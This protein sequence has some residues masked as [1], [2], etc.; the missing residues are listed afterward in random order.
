MAILL[1]AVVSGAAG[2]AEVQADFLVAGGGE[3]AVAAA[4]QAAR[5]GVPRVVLVN[6]VDR[7]G[8]QFSNEG[9]GPVDERVLMDGHSVNFPRSGMH[10]EVV[11]MIRAYNLREYGMESPGNCWSATETIEPGPAAQIFERLLEPEV[12]SGRLK[13]YRG[14]EVEG[15]M[16]EGGRVA[17]ARFRSAGGEELVV[18]ARITADATDWGDVIRL[19]GARHFA[20]VDPRSRFGE[21]SEPEV[22]GPV[23]R[24]EMN[25]VTWTITLR[26][27]DREECVA[28]PPFY[29]PACYTAAPAWRDS[30]IYRE[31]YEATNPPTP[32]TQRRLVDRLHYTLRPGTEA[33]QLNATEQDYPLCMLPP[34]VAAELERMERGASEKNIVEMTPAQRRVVLD[35]AKRHSLG[36]LYFLQNDHPDEATRRRMRRMRLTDE[37]GTPDRL[38]PKPYVREGLRLAAMY[39]L[40]E[41]DVCAADGRPGWSPFRPYDAAMSFQFHIDFHPTRRVFGVGGSPEAWRS[42]HCGTRGWNAQ[43]HRSF[44]PLRSLVPESMD[45][46]L[47]AGRNVGV[48]SIVQAAFRLHGQMILCGQVAG[49]LAARAVE[50]GREPRAVVTDRASVDAVRRALVRGVGGHPGVAIVAWQDLAPDDPR[51]ERANLDPVPDEKLPRCL[52]YNNRQ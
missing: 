47:G 40:R 5:L 39:V 29:D 27:S 12:A 3:A 50:E 31:S 42:R 16:V 34:R 18:R 45:G 46:L 20:G 8:G 15:V 22:V 7:F 25:P 38:P 17:G 44:L 32:Y 6:D 1:A 21:P 19:S 10:L 48:S 11:R 41:Q 36:Y 14:F 23:E 51:F 37:F 49:T 43:S 2:A 28:R 33:I 26:E 35:D 4:V 52:W 30:G 13:V 24:Q 9:V